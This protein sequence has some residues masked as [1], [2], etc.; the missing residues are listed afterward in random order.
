GEL[1]QE[2]VRGEP[3]H[4]HE[5]DRREP[6]RDRHEDLVAVKTLRD[7]EEVQREHE[8]E[9]D[10]RHDERGRAE[11]RGL[12]ADDRDESGDGERCDPD[13]QGQLRET[14]PG[15]G[16]HSPPSSDHCSK[17]S[18][19]RPIASS[20]PYWSRSRAR[21]SSPLMTVPLV[22]PASSIHHSPSANSRSACF[23][24]AAS[25]LITTSLPAS[26]PIE[27]MARS[28]RRSPTRAAPRMLRCTTRWA[29]PEGRAATTVSVTRERWSAPSARVRTK[30]ARLAMVAADRQ[31]RMRRARLLAQQL[32]AIEDHGVTRCDR[33]KRLG[34]GGDL[35]T[36]GVAERARG[37][38][39]A[40]RQ[41]LVALGLPGRE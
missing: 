7:E 20:S 6:C 17:R 30:R 39:F 1:L 14:C 25:S 24:E 15:A 35:V 5:A 33:A 13:Q 9:I 23:A 37:A 26:R 10:R 18:A 28:G 27:L 11:G 41:V 4:E 21:T 12:G 40:G 22:L 3:L 8:D 31:R 32:L 38:E 34:V 29:M 16:G 19:T 2:Q 36:R